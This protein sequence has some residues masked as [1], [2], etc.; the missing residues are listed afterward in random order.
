MFFIFENSRIS[1]VRDFP[2]VMRP[3]CLG[4]LATTK[5]KREDKLI[6]LLYTLGKALETVIVKIFSDYAKDYGL[7]PDQQIKAR[8][9]RLTE[10]VFKNLVNGVYTV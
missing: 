3:S 8:R 5:L 7:L 9:G 1:E 2:H 10:T 6:V 4:L